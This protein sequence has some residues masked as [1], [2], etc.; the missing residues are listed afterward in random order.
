MEEVLSVG[1][2]AEHFDGFRDESLSCTTEVSSRKADGSFTHRMLSA[3]IP[4]P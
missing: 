4:D 2:S 1:A 3:V